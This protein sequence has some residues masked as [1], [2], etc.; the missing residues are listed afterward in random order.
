VS[1]LGLFGRRLIKEESRQE[2]KVSIRYEK[3][4]LRQGDSF[5]KILKSSWILDPLLAL[6]DFIRQQSIDVIKR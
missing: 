6:L 1:C 4:R 3:L 2:S 5:N